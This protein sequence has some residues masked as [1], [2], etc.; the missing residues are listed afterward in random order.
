MQL[1]AA[2][3]TDATTKQMQH[4]SYDILLFRTVSLHKRL[5]G[6][7][8][9][10]GASLGALECWPTNVVGEADNPCLFELVAAGDIHNEND[11]WQQIIDSDDDG[12]VDGD[13]DGN[14]DGDDDGD[15]EGDDGPRL[16]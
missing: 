3:I 11:K 2:Y 10:P 4:S 13:D 15:D 5:L 8:R 7:A 14:D 16:T 12:D 6:K 1:K 9:G